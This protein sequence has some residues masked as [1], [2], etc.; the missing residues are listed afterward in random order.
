MTK[1]L[2]HFTTDEARILWTVLE[3]A[4]DR[5]SDEQEVD[6]LLG[7]QLTLMRRIEEQDFLNNLSLSDELAMGFDD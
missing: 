7:L 4:I 5:A 2:F 3:E 6:T 1:H